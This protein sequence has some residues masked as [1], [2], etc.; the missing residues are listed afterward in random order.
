MTVVQG[1]QINQIEIGPYLI[2]TAF[3]DG[4]WVGNLDPDLELPQQIPA[5]ADLYIPAQATAK[6]FQEAIIRPQGGASPYLEMPEEEAVQ[7]RSEPN[8]YIQRTADLFAPLRE[9]P[10]TDFELRSMDGLYQLGNQEAARALSH[11]QE[12]LAAPGRLRILSK[13]RDGAMEFYYQPYSNS[14]EA[15]YRGRL[16]IIPG[17][18][19]LQIQSL[20][21]ET[22]RRQRLVLRS[23]EA[24]TSIPGV[25]DPQGFRKALLRLW[26]KG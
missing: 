24:L 4:S 11:F 26:V 23:P 10:A 7:C 20:I 22:G 5:Q 1:R 16:E 6:G 18:S 13:S 8:S 2:A 21:L 3:S 17:S 12:C 9:T 25:E 14:P 15:K 19:P